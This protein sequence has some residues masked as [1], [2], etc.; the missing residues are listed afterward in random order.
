MRNI[1]LLGNSNRDAF[2]KGIPKYTLR[3]RVYKRVKSLKN[4]ITYYVLEGDITNR[5]LFC[6]IDYGHKKETA[7]VFF[8]ELEE[9]DS[10]E[11]KDFKMIKLKDLIRDLS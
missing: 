1:E 2:Y 3:D 6:Y 9:V 5:S 7:K 10:Y 4:S 11:D 8:W